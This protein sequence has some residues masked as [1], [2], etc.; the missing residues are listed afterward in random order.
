MALPVIV[1]GDYH[2][3]DSA[4]GSVTSLPGH[5]PYASS[6]KTDL[7][8]CLLMLHISC[9]QRSE[10]NF[11]L[12]GL[13]LQLYIVL[14][15]QQLSRDPSY[16]L[17]ACSLIT[18][19]WMK[20][21][22]K[23]LA[24]RTGDVSSPLLI[25]RLNYLIE[26]WFAA[27]HLRKWKKTQHSLASLPVRQCFETSASPRWV[28]PWS[29][30]F[31]WPLWIWLHNFLPR[32]QWCVQHHPSDLT[33]KSNGAAAVLQELRAALLHFASLLLLF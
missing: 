17:S 16:G 23:S 1:S 25:F 22:G 4:T 14:C 27:A 32:D 15:K 8:F 12:P 10:N 13:H 33:G 5:H 3:Q 11:F 30:H 29:Q 21:R 24:G 7:N 28:S 26:G 19:K 6:D 31:C 18:S 9:S 2:L 20:V